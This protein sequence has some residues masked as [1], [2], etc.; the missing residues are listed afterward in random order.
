MPV[1][2][3]SSITLNKNEVQDFKVFNVGTGNPTLSSGGDIGY[4]WTD[5]T[6]S[7]VLKW[8][9][10]SAVRTL[11]DSSSTTI[12]AADL[13]GG[14]AGSLPY[15]QGASDTTFLGIGTAGQV[16]TVASGAPAWTSQ[17]NLSVG[18]ATWLNGGAQGDIPVQ[19]AAGTTG[20]LNIGANG[21]ILTSNGT[22]P[23]WSASI[24]S[25]SVSGLAAS[26]TTDTT[27]ASN[28]SSGTLP[29]ARLA[30]ANGSL[31]VGDASN[32]PAATAK[33][34]IP[35]SGFGAAAADVSMGTYK[36]TNLG[37]PLS[38]D[39]D[40]TAATKGYVDSVAQ[41]L[42]VKASCV[43]ASTANI[44][45]SAPGSITIDGV[46]S[47]TFT[48]GT[49]RILV[50]DQS[51]PA[52]NGIY[53][54]NGTGSAMTRSL[55]A[56]TWDELVGAFTFVETGTA[57]ADSGWVCNVNAGGTL[58]TTAVTWTKFSQAGSYT[59][60]NGIVQSG[61]SFNFA[62][63]SAY[64]AGQIPFAGG[65]LGTSSTS[66]G[67]DSNFVWDDQ[68]NRLGIGTATPSESLD[69]NG[70]IYVRGAN[71]LKLDNASNNYVAQIKNTGA[72]GQSS[73]EFLLGSPYGT[74]MTLDNSGNL[75]VGVS[76]S[77]R[78][79][80]KTATDGNHIRVSGAGQNAIT[81]GNNTSTAGQ[82]FL[83]GR[84][85][86]SDNAN[87]FFLY[88]LTS[89]NTRLLIDS[90]GNVG[91]GTATP[92]NRLHVQGAGQ[93]TNAVNDNGD[94][95]ALFLG[96]TGASG[97]NGGLLLIGASVANGVRAQVG[98][99]SLLNDGTAYGTGDMAF[100][101]RT[102]TASTTLTEKMRLT[103]AGNLGL[104]VTPSARLHTYIS[105]GGTNNLVEIARLQRATTGTAAVGFGQY[106]RFD[107]E[108]GD[109]ANE[110]AGF[111]GTKWSNATA[112]VTK[113]DLIFGGSDNGAVTTTMVLDA[114]GNLGVGTPS[115][116]GASGKVIEI[117]GA[118]GQARLV[119]KNDITGSASTDGSQIALVGSQL[120]IQNRENS[121]ITFE[122]NG[123][124]RL[125]INSS[126]QTLTNIN[127]TASAPSFSRLSDENTGLYFP[128]A[129]TLGL[130]TGGS[131]RV[132]IGST[133][134]VLIGS[135]VDPGYGR[136]TVSV[137]SATGGIF[138]ASGTNTNA[139]F[140]V[141]VT[142]DQLIVGT[143]TNHKVT[144]ITNDTTRLTLKSTGQLNFT[145]LNSAPA[146]AVGDLYYNSTSNTLQYHN[147]SAFQQISRKVS[148]AGA[149]TGTT[150]T[151]THNFG[152]KDVI[153]QVR[154]SSDAQVLTD[155]S[156]ATNSVTVT[157]A[158]SQTLSNY[159]VTVIG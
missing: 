66:I 73:L 95:S 31:Y 6:G 18:S 78:L 110:V 15:Q 91:I 3:L 41:G 30:L 64:T 96:D 84:S 24:P 112:G 139:L 107:L 1:P 101:T 75:G 93:A 116:S 121:E 88:D 76:P 108:R 48:S 16:L 86:S 45:L 133:G 55:D 39:P 90:S 109:G 129:D 40:S 98:I 44:T 124:E 146:G 119:L 106:L 79:D 22:T 11:L 105:D 128:A 81:F 132:T 56:N 130:V 13:S 70:A 63:S 27:S 138:R 80:V 150:I 25:S 46:S 104:G 32:N 144:F 131:D 60:G 142:D 37:T 8:W 115:P 87:N 67:F 34:S 141:A 42:D 149:G 65:T 49:T 125:R 12:V 136:T 62:Q 140:C 92:I 47:A 151:V 137:Y 153:V 38:T 36:I 21:R 126:G 156:Y 2:F 20:F 68:A 77:F 14:A 51:A 111:I 59:A 154:D 50:K 83:L 127:G 122:T 120:V 23:V 19:S 10:G 26:A 33:S 145:G 113:G 159:T 135:T 52:E 7:K 58:G 123:N 134:N 69:V 61:T 97:N 118:A 158:S 28:I 74:K 57:N 71:A 4:F 9:D 53:I 5:T 72:S 103:T 35:L 148:A 100:L 117:N 114:S 85:V 29:L 152:T 82:G 157:F 147:N 155:V 143:T 17:S 102:T 99:K 89:G 43:V 94:G 54:W